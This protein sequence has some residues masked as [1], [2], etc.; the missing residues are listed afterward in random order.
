MFGTRSIALL[1]VAGGLALWG[2][3]DSQ[4]PGT[5]LYS[6]K[7]TD[8]AGPFKAATVTISQVYLQGSGGKT[9]LT[10]TPATV[11]LLDLQNATLD[12]VKNAEIPTGTYTE[13]RLVVTGGD[14]G[15]QDGSIFASSPAS[16]WLPPRAPR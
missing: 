8:A 14:V 9:T 6:V 2:C 3:G 4:A 7:L 11:N 5:A 13:L 12:L 1:A 16:S 10:S 15:L